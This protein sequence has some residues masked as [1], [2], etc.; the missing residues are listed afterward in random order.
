MWPGFYTKGRPLVK[1]NLICHSDKLS[2]QP[3]CPVLNINIQDNFLYQPRKWL[4]G[5]PARK[6]VAL[7]SNYWTEKVKLQI[8]FSWSLKNWPV[9]QFWFQGLI[10]CTGNENIQPKHLGKTTCSS[11]FSIHCDESVTSC[12]PPQSTRLPCGPQSGHGHQARAPLTLLN[13]G[14]QDHDVI[15]IE[16]SPVRGKCIAPIFTVKPLRTKSQNWNVSHIEARC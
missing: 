5:Q 8:P 10:E 12:Q 15:E 14:S 13:A 2:W 11:G 6:L 3:G 4:F 16:D 9:L 1:S 7:N